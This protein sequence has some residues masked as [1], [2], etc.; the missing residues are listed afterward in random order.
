MW[1][2]RFFNSFWMPD[3]VMEISGI[4]G[5]G[6]Q[7]SE[8]RGVSVLELVKAEYNVLFSTDF[9]SSIRHKLTTMFERWYSREVTF[10]MLEER[11]KALV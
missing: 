9:G 6:L 11:P 7:V 1:G 2:L 3:V 10:C 5:K 4:D 8:G